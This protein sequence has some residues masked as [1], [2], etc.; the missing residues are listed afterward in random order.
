MVKCEHNFTANLEEKKTRGVRIRIVYRLVI[1][2]DINFGVR[3][4]PQVSFTPSLRLLTQLLKNLDTGGGWG[5]KKGEG[6]K[7][8]II[9]D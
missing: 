6:E 3:C 5:Y 7:S 8:D 2:F 1:V 4:A 9:D